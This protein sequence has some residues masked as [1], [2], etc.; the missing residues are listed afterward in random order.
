MRAR[1][2]WALD[3]FL[4]NSRG[5]QVSASVSSLEAVGLFVC[6]RGTGVC[7][8]FFSSLSLLLP[9]WKFYPHQSR[10]V[11]DRALRHP[12]LSPAPS[13]SKNEHPAWILEHSMVSRNSVSRAPV[14]SNEQH[15][16]PP[17]SSK[18]LLSAPPSTGEAG[19]EGLCF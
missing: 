4:S 15:I 11:T 1:E 7:C 8:P 18:S 10:W 14:V 3:S 12:I 13:F 16:S 5:R 19:G 2:F 9:V 6:A 17:L